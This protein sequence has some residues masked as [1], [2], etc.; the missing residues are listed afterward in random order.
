MTR[1]F[2]IGRQLFARGNGLLRR[3]RSDGGV[4]V[5]MPSELRASKSRA[6]VRCGLS[7]RFAVARATEAAVRR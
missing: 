6:A 3:N 5:A 4:D 1:H 7:T 2:A